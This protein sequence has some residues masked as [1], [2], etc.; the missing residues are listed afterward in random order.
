M[1]SLAYHLLFIGSFRRYI[2]MLILTPIRKSTKPMVAILVLSIYSAVL[3]IPNQRLMVS[4]EYLTC[5]WK[6]ANQ[7]ACYD[8]ELE[9]IEG[10]EPLTEEA[11]VN[12]LSGSSVSARI[13]LIIHSW[14]SI[15]AILDEKKLIFGWIFSW[16]DGTARVM[17]MLPKHIPEIDEICFMNPKFGR[18]LPSSS[19]VSCWWL[20]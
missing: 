17:R 10:G 9:T 18:I 20:G 8:G 5:T 1:G 4:R 7:C 3:L 11:L 16:R 6:L 19:K 13:W 2:N 12:Y 14:T 15:R